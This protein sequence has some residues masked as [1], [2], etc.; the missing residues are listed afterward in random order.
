MTAAG[1]KAATAARFATPSGRPSSITVIRFCS[2][3][4]SSAS[5]AVF[6]EQESSAQLL[7][8]VELMAGDEH[9][10]AA[11]AIPPK[12]HKFKHRADWEVRAAG[13]TLT[14]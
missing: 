14:V 9:G 2:P 13:R 4:N 11:V 8:F 10:D 1:F 12:P 6:D 3:A 5:P 7:Q